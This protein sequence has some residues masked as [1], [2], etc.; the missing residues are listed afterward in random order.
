MAKAFQCTLVTPEEQAFEG[1]VQYASIPAHDGQIG[2][3]HQ[4]APLLVKLG[5]GALRLDLANGQN[6]WFFIGG[7]FAQMKDDKLSIVADEAVEAAKI[8]KA[9]AQGLLQRAR[10]AKAAGDERIEQRQREYD[11]AAAMLAVA[12]HAG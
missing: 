12:G 6:Q 10:Q 1:Q 9:Q 7:G 5:F 8:D 2:L 11:R 4:R 3:M